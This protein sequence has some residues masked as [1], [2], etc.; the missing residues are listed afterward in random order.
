[1]ER[2]RWEELYATG[3]RPDR[4][5]SAW[6]AA[7]LASLPNDLPLADVAGGTGRHAS[8]A[9]RSGFTPVLLDVALV[10]VQRART[11]EPRLMPVVAEATALP[12]APGRFGTVLVTNFLDR[13]AFPGL[14][15]LLAPGGYL[16]YETY[17]R[18]HLDLVRAGLA[19]G[20]SSADF[21]LGP[22]EL[23][24]LV[25]PLRVVHYDEGEVHDEAGRRCSARLLARRR[26]SAEEP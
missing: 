24:T 12:L 20:P 4:P 10:A 21:L 2:A 1:M 13:T 14:I 26:D 9:A 11:A 23:P 8:V 25:A 5:P 15:G 6:V 18:P 22:G 19:R 16:V 17:T 7:T 3:S